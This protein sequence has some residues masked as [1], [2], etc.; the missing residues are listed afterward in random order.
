ME[1]PGIATPQEPIIVLGKENNYLF[2]GS[3]VDYVV[4]S[5]RDYLSVDDSGFPD[6]ENL[7]KN[8]LR[9]EDLEFFDNAGRSLEPV[10]VDGELTGVMVKD[11]QEEI[12]NR[13]R[14][15]FHVIEVKIEQEPNPDV[16]KAL[17]GLP[18]APIS[19][20]QLIQELTEDSP[21]VEAPGEDGFFAPDDVAFFVP[22][23]ARGAPRT[24]KWWNVIW[25]SC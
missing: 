18:D 10:V 7:T 22:V 16:D 24:C 15:M 17:L 9:L 5:T 12:R 23:S 8:R 2:V 20:E 3:T 14:K 11:P 6:V 19:F 25:G 1:Q 21:V 13:L 4:E